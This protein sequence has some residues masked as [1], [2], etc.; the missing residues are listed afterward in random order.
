MDSAPR[1]TIRTSTTPDSASRVAAPVPTATPVTGDACARSPAV[2]ERYVALIAQTLARLTEALANGQVHAPAT[3]AATLRSDL[4]PERGATLLLAA[5]I[6]AQ[7]LLEL[8]VP[9]DVPRTALQLMAL[10]TEPKASRSR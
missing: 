6:G 1:V 2:R 7:T 3:L 8:G 4:D 9:L 5:V 10:V